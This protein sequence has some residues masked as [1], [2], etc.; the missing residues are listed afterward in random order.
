MSDDDDHGR[1]ELEALLELQ[2][3]ETDI[4]R[5]EK[6]L[7]EL[8]EQTA[9]D[10][11]LETS[12]KIEATRDQLRVDRDMVDSRIRSVE[13]DLDLLQERRAKEQQ[14]MYGGEI[15]NPRELQAIRAEIDDVEA[16]I[17]RAEEELLEKMEEREKLTGQIGQLD[18]RRAE[19]ETEQEDLTAKRD[20]AAQSILA[21]LG[22]LKA[23]RDAVLERIPD[24]LLERFER[25]KERHGALALGALEG[26]ICTACRL[27]LTPLERSDLREDAPALGTCPQCQRLLVA[28]D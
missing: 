28:L 14:R 4:R 7:D 8:P 9:L 11:S 26:G 23:D 18:E 10:E 27:E 13:G 1:D 12:E 15:S 25:A 22:Q 17:E 2:R 24:Q 20:S 3:T 16:R 6:R 5:L 19:L 21:D